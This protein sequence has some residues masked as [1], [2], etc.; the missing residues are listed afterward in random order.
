MLKI[1]DKVKFINDV[2][3]GKI[4]GFQ[5]KTIAIVENQDGFEIPTLM[6]QLIKIEDVDTEKTINRDF[7]KKPAPVKQVVKEEEKV[8]EP[9]HKPS[10]IKGN[11]DPKFFMAFYPL[12]HK[13]PVGDEIEV[14]IIND[15]N[16]TLLYQYCHFDGEKYKTVDYGEL[17]PNTKNLL[18]S[19]APGNLSDLPK[20]YFR[21]I[22]FMKESKSLSKVVEKEVQ[23]S[24]IKFYKEKS[25]TRSNFFKGPAMAF[26][27]VINP[28]KDEIDKL[29][30]SDFRK[31]VNEKDIENRTE[32]QP[33]KKVKLP[34][35][36]EV[37]LHIE[38]LTDNTSGLSNH[39]ILQIQMDKFHSE[40]KSAIENKIQRIVFIHGVGNG[41]LKQE[42][43]KKLKSTYAKYYFQDAS[44]HE[45]GFGATMVILRRK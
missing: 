39:E 38:Q 43:Y 2:G 15:S 19:I 41:V 37:D 17:E 40:M 23:V 8:K 34:Q 9:E 3:G 7:S 27:L 35:I 45:Y 44:F 24:S 25:F 42:I 5:G 4:T 31:I 33:V 36:V 1:G 29:T 26:D 21:I 14:F 22:P 13:N 20:Y 6:T 10:I 12:D 28:M 16:F 30:D 32:S 11:D 18:E